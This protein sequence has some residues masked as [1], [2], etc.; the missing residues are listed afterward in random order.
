[1]GLGFQLLPVDQH[2]LVLQQ[3]HGGQRIQGHQYLPEY[4]ECKR[5]TQNKLIYLSINTLELQVVQLVQQ[6][7]EDLVDLFLHAGLED[8]VHQVTLVFPVHPGDFVLLGL[9]VVLSHPA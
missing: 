8:P 1:M 2:L 6:G 4:N 3:D 7:L 5:M 9:P